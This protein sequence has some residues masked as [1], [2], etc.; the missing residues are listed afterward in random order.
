MFIHGAQIRYVLV[1]D[2]INF[3]FSS[4]AVPQKLTILNGW[5]LVRGVKK[6]LSMFI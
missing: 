3:L 6:I 1:S 4:V 5:E 2:S